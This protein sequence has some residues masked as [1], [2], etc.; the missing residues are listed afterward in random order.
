MADIII[1]GI[2]QSTFVWAARLACAEKGVA[3]TCVAEVPHSDTILKVHPLGMIPV[4]EHGDV[5]LWESRAIAL[6]VDRAFDGPPLSAPDAAD[7]AL[8]EAWASTFICALERMLIRKYLFAYAF[9]NTPDGR[10]DM[11]AVEEAMPEVRQALSVVERAVADGA[12][13]GERFR[14]PDLWALPILSYVSGLPEWES[15]SAAVPLTKA[16]LGPALQRPAVLATV[17]PPLPRR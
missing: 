12:I 6:Y 10:P 4:L 5:Q 3:H 9:P 15:L 13:L 2:S 17:P 14:L 7:A 1:K 11:A 16:A 8:E